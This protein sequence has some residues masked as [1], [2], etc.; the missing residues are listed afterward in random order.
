MRY[1]RKKDVIDNKYEV[2]FF[3]HE[4]TYGCSFRVKS[5][6]DGKIYMLKVYD[7]GK[8]LPL[9]FT[10]NDDLLEA[11]IHSG[12]NHPNLSRYIEHKTISH[13]GIEIIYYVVGFI[14]GETLQER[15]NREGPPNQSFAVDFFCGVLDAVNYLH[16][17]DVPILHCDITPQNIM[18]DLSDGLMRP[19]LFDFGLARF[20][21]TRGVHYNKSQPSVYFCAPELLNSAAT[22]QS[23]IYSLGSLLYYLLYGIF[24]WYGESSNTDLNSDAFIS[25]LLNSRNKTLRFNALEGI[26]EQYINIIGKSLLPQ[27]S[28][29]FESV[30]DIKEAINQELVVS[31]SEVELQDRSQVIKRAQGAGFRKIAGMDVIKKMIK[32]E[33]IEPL[34]Y[35]NKNSD[36][37]IEPPN[38][39]LFYGP[40]GCGKTFFAECLADEVGFNFLKIKPS[41]VGSKY[42]HGGQEKISELFKEAKENA[43]SILFLDEMDA[44]IPKRNG[45]MGHHYESEVNE[46][47]VQIN[48]CSKSEVF[49][50]GATN[51]LNKIDTAVLRSGR[52]D[53][54]IHIPIPDHDSR[55]ALFKLQLGKRP[56]VLS[57]DLN[58]E[59]FAEKTKGFVCSD[60]NL[61]VNDAA[62]LA[63]RNQIKI[64]NELVLKVIS[65]TSP[66]VSEEQLEEYTDKSE[67]NK[68]KPEPIIGFNP[69]KRKIQSLEIELDKAVNEQDY[70]RAAKLKA[71]IEKLKE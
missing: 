31:V 45:S 66:S 42:V 21:E 18:M 30:S 69:T 54:K 62:R 59:L 51:R 10:N 39:V 23:D 41:D 14:S 43:P 63:S 19:V 53:R 52:F 61:I 56:K 34:L 49:I 70:D 27:T 11:N 67:N 40:P 50:I 38:G 8:L 24:P 48:N 58:Y 35:P 17:R 25:D 26:E 2:L 1:F 60:L 12:L 32:Q 9:H 64:D 33:V 6:E 22:V 15:I 46:W 7:K 28:T 47:L 20:I 5:I 36:Y 44:M 29:R 16:T 65:E 57:D 71:E 4:T 55:S 13:N 68:K 37:G 3:I